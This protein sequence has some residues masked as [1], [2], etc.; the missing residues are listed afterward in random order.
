[1]ELLKTMQIYLEKTGQFPGNDYWGEQFK[2]AFEADSKSFPLG[3]EVMQKI[4]EERIKE[5]F[6]KYTYPQYSNSGGELIYLES[7][8]PI[9]IT[10][11]E[12]IK[13]LIMELSNFSA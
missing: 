3:A 5:L 1:M 4:A 2:K 7:E 10:D 6:D 9:Y 13:N 12:S 8:L 11:Y